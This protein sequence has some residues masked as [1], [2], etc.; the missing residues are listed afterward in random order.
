MALKNVR[1]S[2]ASSCFSMV[3]WLEKAM[4][5][6]STVQQQPVF[7]CQGISVAVWPGSKTKPASK[8]SI[9]S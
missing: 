8:I 3:G 2:W 7:A 1:E 5:N 9:P 4:C 6:Q